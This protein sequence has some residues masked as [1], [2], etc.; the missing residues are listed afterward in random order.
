MAIIDIP[1]ETI[2][3]RAAS[4]PGQQKKMLEVKTSTSGHTTIKINYSSLS[5]MQSCWR[6]TMLALERGLG[7][8]VRSPALEFGTA[9]HSAL[10]VFYTSP[11]DQRVLPPNYLK[12]LELMAYGNSVQNQEDFLIYRATK[13]FIDRAESL[14]YLSD[15]DKRSIPNGV[16][17]LGHYFKDFINDPYEVYRGPQGAPFVEKYVEHVLYSEPGLTIVLHGTIDVVLQHYSTKQLL[18]CDHKTSSQVG[19]DFYNRLKPNH[20]YTGYLW[21]AREGLGLDTNEFLVNCVEVKARPK[22]ARGSAPNFPRQIT[23]RTQ[24]DFEDF[25]RSVVWYVKQYLEC[26]QSGFWP[27]GS[28]D[29]CAMW[30]G[31][32]FLKVCSAPDSIKENILQAEYEVRK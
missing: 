10:E 9:I 11:R 31:C 18:V 21:L 13:A 23:R 3:Q 26:R 29:S 17:I 20:Q 1:T 6:K 25:R 12:N 5:L 15:T 30:G 2:E 16:W 7:P 14:A 22:T 8:K 24:E 19:K 28:V 4:K 32:G 27:I